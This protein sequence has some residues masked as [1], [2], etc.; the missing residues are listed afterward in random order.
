MIRKKL[1][2]LRLEW[3]LRKVI[4]EVASVSIPRKRFGVKGNRWWDEELERKKKEVLALRRRLKREIEEERKVRMSREYKLVRAQYK[5]MVKEKKEK[6]WVEFVEEEM[7]TDVWALPYKMAVKKIKPKEIVSAVGGKDVVTWERSARELLDALILDDVEE[8]ENDWHKRIREEVRLCEVGRESMRVAE[9]ELRVAVFGMKS[10]KSP[11][12]DGMMVEFVKSG[13]EILKECMLKLY[14][15]CFQ[16]SGFPNVWKRGVIVTLLKSE[17]RD[18]GLAA[19]YRPICLLPVLGKILERLIVMKLEVVFYES[20]SVRQHGFMRGRSTESAIERLRYV[21]DCRQEK[22]VM[23]IFL[24]MT[25]AFDRVWWPGVLWALR[26]RGVSG[27]GYRIMRDYLRGRWLEVRCGTWKIGKRMNRGC[28]QGS[29]LGPQL[30][31]VIFDEFISEIE[32]LEGCEVIV[33]ADD[34]VVLVWGDSRRQLEERGGVIMDTIGQW[35]VRSKMKLSKDKTVI[36]MLKGILS[37]E[38][39]PR[40]RM[41]DQ[42]L[43]AVREVKYLGVTWSRRLFIAAH[44][45]EVTRRARD[46]MMAVMRVIRRS[47]VRYDV[48]RRIYEGMYVAIVAYAAGAWADRLDVKGKRKLLSEQ[49]R[50]LLCMV[51]GYRTLSVDACAVIA[52]A[53]PMDLEIERRRVMSLIKKDGQAEWNV[54]YL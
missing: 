47:S 13:F 50:V 17:E 43:K 5:R 25:G 22:Y 12:W 44:V 52:G 15:A 46:K 18:V 11:G 39:Q 19:S 49:R 14:N 7:K 3:L 4:L 51:K 6:S 42:V 16:Y 37:E 8:G 29:V 1:D 31:K 54:R 33:Y 32:R 28:P 10:G 53:L 30:W 20:V 24:D 40:V 48:V 9:S 27:D 34:G 38:R 45:E 2:V 36:M 21:V 41:G 26:N 23:G 35:C